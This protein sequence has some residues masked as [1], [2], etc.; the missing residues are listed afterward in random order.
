MWGGGASVRAHRVRPG[1]R[2]PEATQLDQQ[3]ALLHQQLVVSWSQLVGGKGQRSG[4]DGVSTDKHAWSSMARRATASGAR[5]PVPADTLRGVRAFSASL[6]NC[7]ACKGSFITSE[8]ALVVTAAP[9][10]MRSSGGYTSGSIAFAASADAGESGRRGT[11]CAREGRAVPAQVG[12]GV[13][14]VPGGDGRRRSRS[15]ARHERDPPQAARLRRSG[16]AAAAARGSHLTEATSLPSHRDKR[17]RVTARS[18]HLR[19]GWRSHA[20]AARR[21]STGT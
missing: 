9:S 18:P 2:L 14:A 11:G 17:A 20:P 10:L 13:R 19:A 8:S 12:V 1:E 7:T 4:V 21:R 3:Q 5:P 15:A 16:T 6:Y